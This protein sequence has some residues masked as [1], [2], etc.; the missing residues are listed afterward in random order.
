MD[1]LSGGE[2]YPVAR[3][4]SIEPGRYGLAFRL[5][6]GRWDPLPL[7]GTLEEVASGAAQMLAPHLDPPDK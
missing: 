1:V 3:L 4:T 7:H 6:T 2:T 5:H